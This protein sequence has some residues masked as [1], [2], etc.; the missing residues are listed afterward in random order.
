MRLLPLTLTCANYD[1]IMALA[2]GDVRPEGIDLKVVRLST[3]EIFARADAHEPDLSEFS[4]GK[5]IELRSRGDQWWQAI[6]VFLSRYFRHWSIY[7]NTNSGIREPADLKGKRVGV[8]NYRFTSSVWTRAL[9]Q[10]E[11]GIQPADMRWVQTVPVAP[12]GD[13]AVQLE[14][15]RGAD[16]NQMI[17]KGEIDVL[18]SPYPPA[19]MRQPGSPVR[20][21]LSNYKELETAFYKQTGVL[22]QMHTVVI[23]NDILGKNSRMAR[24]LYQ[25]FCQAKDWNMDRLNKLQFMLPWLH[26]QLDELRNLMGPNHWPYGREANRAGVEALTGYMV[27]QKLIERAVPVDDLFLALD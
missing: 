2:L 6:P 3:E 17:L 15:I 23:R 11:F 26:E 8:P 16:L 21:L 10:H 19:A 5:Y 4:L 24:S 7:V 9:L 22:P 1:R 20:R 12:P 13:P 25:A 14:T 27:E 18:V